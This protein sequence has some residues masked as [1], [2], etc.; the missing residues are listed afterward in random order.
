M[1]IV[2]VI[3]NYKKVNKQKSEALEILKSFDNKYKFVLLLGGAPRNWY[4]NKPAN[5]LDIYI[6]LD[7][8][9]K[10]VE[11]NPYRKS[12][13]IV[14]NVNQTSEEKIKRINKEIRIEKD[15]A[16]KTNRY[17]NKKIVH[18]YDGMYKEQHIQL[19]FIKS[20]KQI[21]TK[22]QFA[23]TIFSTFDFGICMIGMDSDGKTYQHQMFKEDVYNKTFSVRTRDLMRNN[24][25]GAKK[26]AERFRKMEL[27]FPNHKC[28]II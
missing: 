15:L 8:E 22:K 5:D 13:E 20:N 23:E 7:N 27:L 10:R 28:R 12:L 19:I 4:Y 2:D 6:Y 25:D 18:L 26:L 17:N 9:E 1:K 24:P 3:K 21:K 16:K 14:P 11:S